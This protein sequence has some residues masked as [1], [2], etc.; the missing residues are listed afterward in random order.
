MDFFEI[1]LAIV[2]GIRSLLR[3]MPSWYIG[4]KAIFH[5]VKLDLTQLFHFKLC[6]FW[7]FMNFKALIFIFALLVT[8]VYHFLISLSTL[9]ASV[10]FFL[11]SFLL[12]IL[13]R[14]LLYPY[15]KI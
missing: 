14:S 12:I 4:E 6:K 7:N 8:Q 1:E 9:S 3:K 11:S 10:F 5:I 13:L 15:N 2:I